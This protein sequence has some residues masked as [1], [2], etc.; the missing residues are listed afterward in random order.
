VN[1][2]KCNHRYYLSA[3]KKILNDTAKETSENSD[4]TMAC[5]NKG[6]EKIKV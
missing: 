2:T 3:N 5:Y 4:I 1:P 6:V